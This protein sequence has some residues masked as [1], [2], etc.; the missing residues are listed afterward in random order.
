MVRLLASACTVLL[1]VAP[2]LTVGQEASM[3]QSPAIS[4]S[5]DSAGL[6]SL[7]HDILEAANAND[8][9]KE[10]R[11]IHSLVMPDDATWFND[12]FG[13]AFGPRLSK[14]YRSAEPTLE[15]E[16]RTIFENDA[17]RGW[18]N[19]KIIRY[20]DAAEVD[21]PTDNFLNC[22]DEPAPLYQTAFINDRPSFEISLSP[23]ENRVG[24]RVIAGDLDGYY[25]HAGGTFRF[26]PENIFFLLPKG[27][28]IRI[29]VGMD[30]MRSKKIHDASWSYPQEAVRQH[31]AG[32]VSI[33]I[34]LDT[35]GKVLQ[36]DLLEGPPILGNAVLEAVKQ[37]T[38]EPTLLDG[39]EVEVETN[40][41]AAFQYMAG[42]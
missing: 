28:P 18:L 41:E 23:G 10:G 15:P 4:Y 24:S 13:P 32:K 6:Q 38:F 8:A 29:Q 7:L 22:M 14:A 16:I 3:T 35:S 27:R 20:A 26:V 9:T 42:K 34:V 19:P 25:V 12:E 31:I 1:L 30:I 39:E 5:A 21:S 17:K 37:W 33:H 40:L 36:A 2:Q 11:L